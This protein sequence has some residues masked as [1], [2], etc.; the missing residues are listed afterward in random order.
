MKKM[1]ILI[2]LKTKFG[3]IQLE[4]GKVIKQLSLTLANFKALPIDSI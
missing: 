2:T 4:D 1:K 3:M